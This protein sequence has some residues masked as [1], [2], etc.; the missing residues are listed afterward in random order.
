MGSAM[1]CIFAA[2]IAGCSLLPMLQCCGTNL[3]KGGGGGGVGGD[4]CS[5]TKATSPREH[6]ED[7]RGPE[8]TKD[9]LLRGRLH[10]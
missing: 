8:M 1:R 6:P 4:V 7:A 3:G 9:V 10:I 5:S 2:K